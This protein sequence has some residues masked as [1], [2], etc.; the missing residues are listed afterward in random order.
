MEK[1]KS[2][3]H[4]KIRIASVREYDYD[5][6]K[7]NEDELHKLSFSYDPM[8]VV[9]KMKEIVPEFKSHYSRYEVLD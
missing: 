6:A 4:P 1:T 2:T 3:Y 7:Q 5:Q 9:K 8:K